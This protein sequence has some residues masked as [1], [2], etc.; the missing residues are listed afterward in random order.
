M[1]EKDQK[2]D[3]GKKTL[4]QFSTD[5][6]SGNETLS[7]INFSSYGIYP[8]HLKNV[9]Y[10]TESVKEKIISGKYVDTRI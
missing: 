7:S 8:E 1:L 5:R 2:E 10:V 4:E 9:D 6:S 3:V